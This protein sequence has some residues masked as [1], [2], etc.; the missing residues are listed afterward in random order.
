MQNR[1]AEGLERERELIMEQWAAQV[2]AS[3]L[4]VDCQEMTLRLGSVLYSDLIATMQGESARDPE[5]YKDALAEC[6]I[7]GPQDIFQTI[8]LLRALENHIW[9]RLPSQLRG[10][11]APL[12]R[13]LAALDQAAF[14]CMVS[15]FSAMHE[16]WTSYLQLLATTDTLTGCVSRGQLEVELRDEWERASRY[17]RNF[18][19]LM[20]DIDHMKT[21]NDT[22]GH[23]AGDTLLREV[24]Q[25]MASRVRQVD[26]VGRYGGDEFVIVMPETTRE[27]MEALARRLL[28]AVADFHPSIAL[29]TP[30]TLSIGMVDSS[31]AFDSPSAMLQAAD[32]AMYLA[33]SAGGDAYSDGKSVTRGS[34]IRPAAVSAVEPTQPLAE[35]AALSEQLRQ[36]L[37]AL[38]KQRE[39]LSRLIASLM[40]RLGPTTG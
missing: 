30:V 29:P 19:V 25:F 11:D 32:K 7:S 40:E 2:R 31:P 26:I 27:G 36:E 17:G 21:V 8:T 16:A 38:R 18:S 24:A 39:E 22:L 3:N 20:V 23:Q 33:K 14:S 37:E 10:A 13:H 1:I 15:V 5:R 4:S 9:D 28:V 12:V 35:P 6:R 34:E